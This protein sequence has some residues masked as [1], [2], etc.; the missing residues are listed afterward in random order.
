MLLWFIERSLNPLDVEIGNPARGEL[1]REVGLAHVFGD[2][3]LT[4]RGA[5]TGPGG[6]R[7]TV[8]YPHDEANVPDA[9]LAKVGY[10]ETAQDWCA[11]A[12]GAYWCG[13]SKSDAVNPETLRRERGRAGVRVWL[14]DGNA[15]EIGRALYMNGMTHLPRK[16]RIGVGGK[17]A[18]SDV[19][20]AF[21]EF[22]AAAMA[23]WEEWMKAIDEG[24]NAVYPLDD[25]TR[26]ASLGLSV[27]Y[28]VGVDEATNVLGLF[29]ESNV[30]DACLATISWPNLQE[31][32]KSVEESEKKKSGATIPS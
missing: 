13:K 12:G 31:M 21:A 1:L 6:N 27:N 23:F 14:G 15:W 32:R 8:L 20:E 4:V 10:Y 3:K 19:I 29:D 16:L 30:W 11:C 9:V 17:A 22:N 25:L 18:P 5:N 7:G 28:R 24:R 26:L 2:A